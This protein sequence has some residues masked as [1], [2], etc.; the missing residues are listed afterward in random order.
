MKIVLLVI[1][2]TGSASPAW[3]LLKQNVKDFI[4]CLQVRNQLQSVENEKKQLESSAVSKLEEGECSK[5]TFEF[6]EIMESELQCSICAELFVSA[7]VLNCSH[8][9]CKYC[10]TMWKKKKKDCPICRWV[11]VIAPYQHYSLQCSYCAEMFV[12]AIVFIS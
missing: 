10:I 5:V 3:G 4:I 9:F 11:N 6:G 1:L 7:I 8:T 2:M 12:S